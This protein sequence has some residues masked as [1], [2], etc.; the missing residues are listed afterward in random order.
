MFSFFVIPYILKFLI[1]TGGTVL[2]S[3]G[4]LF[5]DA[6]GLAGNYPVTN[7]TI[8]ISPAVFGQMVSIDFT[9]FKTQFSSFE[10]DA[11]FI[12]DGVTATGNN[13]GKL[14]GDYSK[15]KQEMAALSME[16]EEE[17]PIALIY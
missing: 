2:V 12:Y 1:S 9:Y 8:T 5:Y 3:G 14:M 11:L 16:L 4:E 6:G 10:Q 7:Y 17:I 15:K 13:I